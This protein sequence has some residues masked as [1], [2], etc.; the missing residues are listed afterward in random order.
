MIKILSFLNHQKTTDPFGGF[1]VYHP[2]VNT[3]FEL[4]SQEHWKTTNTLI[5]FLKM[6]GPGKIE[7]VKIN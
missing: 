5:I 3:F 7:E 6:I 1:Y 2:T 4:A